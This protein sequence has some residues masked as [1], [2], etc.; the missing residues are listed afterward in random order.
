MYLQ[1]SQG[2][3]S[4]FPW[5]EKWLSYK[6]VKIS[7]IIY[8]NNNEHT[9]WALT[10]NSQILPCFSFRRL[11]HPSFLLHWAHFLGVSFL[12]HR[13]SGQW[14]SGRKTTSKILK[15][16]LTCFAKT[17]V[18]DAPRPL[19]M[20]SPGIR[21]SPP[22]DPILTLHQTIH[23]ASRFWAKS[24]DGK[25]VVGTSLGF[26]S[27]EGKW[28]ITVHSFFFFFFKKKLFTLCWGLAD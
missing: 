28:V 19:S 16:L 6:L 8:K 3:P 10:Q 15:S 1:P 14:N 23:S 26:T 9:F 5:W 4:F 27:C 22:S 25:F 24:T 21:F 12:S 11:P 17:W 7:N 18:Q 2:C 13:M 20:R